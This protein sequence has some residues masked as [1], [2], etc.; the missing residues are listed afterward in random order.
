MAV[1]IVVAAALGACTER[2]G[3][4]EIVVDCVDEVTYPLVTDRSNYRATLNIANLSLLTHVVPDLKN[5]YSNVEYLNLEGNQI[6]HIYNNWGFICAASSTTGTTQCALRGVNLARNHLSV[7]GGDSFA[8]VPGIWYLD[9]RQNVI[10]RI[11]RGAFDLLTRLQDLNLAGN[12]IELYTFSVQF[13][14]ICTVDLSDQYNGSPTCNRT[15]VAQGCAYQSDFDEECENSLACEATQARCFISQRRD[16]GDDYRCFNLDKLPVSW[17]D[18]ATRPVE[19]LWMN[20]NNITVVPHNGF[21]KCPY[22]TARELHLSANQITYVGGYA[23]GTLPHLR[24]I[25]LSANPIEFIARAALKGL[26]A[27]VTLNLRGLHLGAF[28]FQLLRVPLFPLAN[29]D[30]SGQLY[31][32]VECNGQSR[33]QS[34]ADLAHSLGQ[35]N[36][37]PT[38]CPEGAMGCVL[39]RGPAMA[40]L[41]A[42]PESEP[43]GNTA[44][45][46]TG[47]V[48]VGIIAGYALHQYRG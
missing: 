1:A 12:R 23:L 9:L 18:A 29:L 44:L 48:F 4:P 31:A 7:I 28:D 47:V 34:H 15:A 32:A 13:G 17:D 46:I 24:V 14:E 35:C 22:T 41:E 5:K 6:T 10:T 45:V 39:P 36:P 40:E 42:T 21:E 16:A 37:S 3:L 8:G 20:G 26:T 25:D 19:R 11:D 33:W 30:V 2:I 27:L 38:S 43:I